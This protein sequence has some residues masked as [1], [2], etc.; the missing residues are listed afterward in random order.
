MAN[1][2]F[3]VQSM[4]NAATFDSYTKSDAITVAT[5]K[6]DIATAVGLD[7][8]WFELSYNNLVLNTAQTLAYYEIGRAHV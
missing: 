3:T 6:S 1:V 2:T 7:T 8:T 4:L 5:L